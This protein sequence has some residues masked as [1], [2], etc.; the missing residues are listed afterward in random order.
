V[1]EHLYTY[2]DPPSQR[3]LD[4]ACSILEAGGVLV[5]P[6]DF[7]WALGCD[8]TSTKGLERIQKLKPE[9][10]KH[11]P[12]SLLCSSISMAADY[13][14]IDHHVY[15]WIKKLWPGPYT[16]LVERNRNLP[17]YIKD[18]R[19]VVGLRIPD[20]VLVVALIEKLGKPLAT[21]SVP[22]LRNGATPRFG[23]EVVE[24]IGHGVDLVLDLGDELPGLEST[25]VDF[26]QGFAE[27]IREGVGDASI[28]SGGN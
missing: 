1:V 4:Q 22:L 21:T 27:V 6:T 5:Y 3:H 24:S 10:P 20:N 13:G 9:H 23:Y 15:R 2:V 8:A 18:K 19:K 17:R 12:F 26:T 14:N 28:F 11:R 16:I 25:I 7:N